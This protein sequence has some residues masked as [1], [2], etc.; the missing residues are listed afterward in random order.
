MEQ[1]PIKDD[2]YKIFAEA[3]SED[4]ASNFFSYM[5]EQYHLQP[6]RSVEVCPSLYEE[7]DEIFKR[8]DYD[9]KLLHE[10]CD[11][12]MKSVLELEKRRKIMAVLSSNGGML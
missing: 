2:F 11:R 9:N 1:T 5:L 12:Y 8:N 4:T 10:T 6:Q 3:S 7:I